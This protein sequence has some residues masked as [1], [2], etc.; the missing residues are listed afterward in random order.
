MAK[1]YWPKWWKSIKIDS[2]HWQIIQRS[3]AWMA[4]SLFEFLFAYI[5]RLPPLRCCCCIRCCCL[6]SVI[7]LPSWN[8]SA[9]MLSNQ[10]IGIRVVQKNLPGF[11]ITIDIRFLGSKK[12]VRYWEQSKKA[13][14][15]IN[16]SPAFKVER[17]RPFL[18]LQSRRIASKFMT[19]SH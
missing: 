6:Y 16:W 1:S 2:H 9:K 15:L 3:V 19:G 4:F 5:P 11:L 12:Y 17:K 7:S 14:N 10:C 8:G 18:T 13:V